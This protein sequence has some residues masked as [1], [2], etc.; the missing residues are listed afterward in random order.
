M[1]EQLLLNLINLPETFIGEAPIAINEC[2]WIKRM[3]GSSILYFNKANYDK[4]TFS[5]YV[6]GSSNQETATRAQTLFNT[7]RNYGTSQ[8]ALIAVRLP[9]F[10]GK[11]DKHRTIY[12]FQLE[13]Q[14]G[15]H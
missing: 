7:M 5:I 11:D 6:R 4:P 15:G 13:Y 3:S 1:V 10:I 9:S 8:E 2:Q 12:T 14:T